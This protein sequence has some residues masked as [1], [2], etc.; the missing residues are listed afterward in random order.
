MAI[1]KIPGDVVSTHGSY[2][3][4]QSELAKAKNKVEYHWK[5]FCESC[6]KFNLDP[7][8]VLDEI[9]RSKKILESKS[10][11]IPTHSVDTSA[12]RRSII[13][14]IGENS[15]SDVD[16]FGF[17]NAIQENT[18]GLIINPEWL[19]DNTHLV[20]GIV[21]G[22]RK[23][24]QLTQRGRRYKS[25]SDVVGGIRFHPDNITNNKGWTDTGNIAT[26]TAAPA[27][28]TTTSGTTT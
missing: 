25:Q 24:Y 9:E 15:V 10:I 7:E 3:M 8:Y 27:T 1:N 14:Y 28:S 22:G 11:T 23:M 5:I 21:M 4:A 2:M 26:D 16:L 13:G 17:F 20:E 12:V 6:K 18:T 19:N